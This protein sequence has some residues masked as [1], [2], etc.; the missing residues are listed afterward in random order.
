MQAG[1]GGRARADSYSSLDCSPHG[2]AVHCVQ[3]PVHRRHAKLHCC[4]PCFGTWACPTCWTHLPA[5][6]PAC[7]PDL[8][9]CLLQMPDCFY[10]ELQ[11]RPIIP[12]HPP[13]AWQELQ[14]QSGELEAEVGGLDPGTKYAFRCVRGQARRCHTW[15]AHCLVAAAAAAALQIA[16]RCWGWAE[17]VG[18]ATPA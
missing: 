11:Y 8:T 13:G 12:S 7:P 10:W 1:L 16:A 6:L 17:H 18:L 2:V 14:V 5:S 15:L 4:P 9:T 3:L